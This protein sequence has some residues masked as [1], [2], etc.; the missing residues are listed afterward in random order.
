MSAYIS[1]NGFIALTLSAI[2]TSIKYEANGILLGH[3]TGD[4]YYVENAIPYQLAE[5]TSTSTSVSSR[6]Q[7]RIRRVFKNYMKYEIIGEFHTHPDGGIELSKSDKNFVRERGYALEVV[8]AIN[9][10]S[11]RRNW[12][13]E[14][15][16]LSG[17]IDKYFIEIGCWKVKEKN[18]TKLTIRCPFA[19][20]FDSAKPL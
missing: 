2:E 10:G 13:Y 8:I 4:V 9:K 19:V 17:S 6:K 7:K 15:G 16:K 12:R 11:T 1:E 3:K 5:R 20:G 18:A 14:R